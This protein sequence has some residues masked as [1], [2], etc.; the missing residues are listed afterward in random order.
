MKQNHLTPVEQ[1]YM[2]IL[3]QLGEGTVHDILARL[4]HKRSAAYTT[5]STILRILEQKGAVTS[6]KQGR[7]HIYK[8][9]LSKRAFARDWLE[10][11]M[12]LFAGSP[13][14]LVA[15]LLD[16][17]RISKEEL[18]AIERLLEAKKKNER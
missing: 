1:E 4:P 7:R 5:V 3:W 11:L 18:I 9:K 8:P 10:R 2:E 13:V 12:N 17:K 15:N 14:E 6:R 16:K